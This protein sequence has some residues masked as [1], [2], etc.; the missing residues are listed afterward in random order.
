MTLFSS[1]SLRPQTRIALQHPDSQSLD[2]GREARRTL[3]PWKSRL[4]AKA[5]PDL[6]MA[7]RGEN[8]LTVAGF[9][10]QHANNSWLERMSGSRVTEKGALAYELAS[11]EY[12]GPNRCSYRSLHSVLS[13]LRHCFRYILAYRRSP[14][15]SGSKG[16]WQDRCWSLSGA[17]VPVVV[18]AELLMLESPVRS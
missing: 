7:K 15:R 2:H 8:S 16:N 11:M 13:H 5:G 9:N 1:C 12:R 18:N 4:S 17:K 6:K 10:A 14:G 3:D